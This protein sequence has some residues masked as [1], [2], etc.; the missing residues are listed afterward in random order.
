MFGG[1]KA[2]QNEKT[3]FAPKS[4]YGASKLFSH[5]ITKI[6]RESY[7]LFACSGI[8][9]NHESP[10]RGETFV[11]KKIVQSV[12]NYYFGNKSLLVL[13]NLNARRDW[14]H[15]K[16]YVETMWKI[17]QKKKPDDF[18]ISTGKSFSVRDFVEEAYK[19]IG[20]KIKWVGKGENEIG[21][22]KNSKEKIIIVSKKYFRPNEVEYLKGDSKKAK[23]VLK[24]N[25]KISFKKLVKEMIEYEIN[26]KN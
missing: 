1:S 21:I 5:W 3:Y 6:Y 17:L 10:R 15:A 20:V 25:P 23:K 2:P 22:N 12:A 24:W 16:D 7:G 18:V 13:G 14:G 11:T 26:S 9:F 8:L 19:N 4:P